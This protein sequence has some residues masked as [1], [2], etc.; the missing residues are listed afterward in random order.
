[1]ARFKAS[2]RLRHSSQSLRPIHPEK[3][4]LGQTVPIR[5]I[6]KFC[7]LSRS[8][9]CA[10]QV[11]SS[12][13]KVPVLRSSP[14]PRLLRSISTTAQVTVPLLTPKPV[15][16]RGA[17]LTLNGVA[18][19]HRSFQRAAVQP[20]SDLREMAISFSSGDRSGPVRICRRDCATEGGRSEAGPPSPQRL[21]CDGPRRGQHNKPIAVEKSSLSVT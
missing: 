2:P 8:P 9:P 18:G 4:F 21:S 20:P 13:A 5:R 12:T 1:M 3:V 17:P 14:S 6:T 19:P 15:R 10:V 11:I 7:L 16:C